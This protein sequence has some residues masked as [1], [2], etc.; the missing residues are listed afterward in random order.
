WP[1]LT[2][3]LVD[4]VLAAQRHSFPVEEPAPAERADARELEEA[5]AE[6]RAQLDI[7]RA[8]EAATRAV[9]ESIAKAPCLTDLL[10]EETSGCCDCPAC[11][12]R[13]AVTTPSEPA[14]ARIARLEAVAD[15]AGEVAQ[16]GTRGGEAMV[17]LRAA[18]AALV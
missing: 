2:A 4:A 13:A 16:R 14:V 8:R 9:L 15:A 5:L 18:L 10:G 11:I 12:A 7:T 1:C 3:R 17:Q 6:A